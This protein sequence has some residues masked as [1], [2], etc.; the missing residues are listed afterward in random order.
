MRST[1]SFNVDFKMAGGLLDFIFFSDVENRHILFFISRKNSC[2]LLTLKQID[3]IVE[4]Q[5]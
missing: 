4:I 1:D 3:F 2:Y 5:Y